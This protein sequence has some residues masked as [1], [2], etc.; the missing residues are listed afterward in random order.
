MCMVM[1]A[2]DAFTQRV[3]DNSLHPCVTSAR[4][5]SVVPTY[6]SA[7]VIGCQV[8][9]SVYVNYKKKPKET[10]SS[11]KG[12]MNIVKKLDI[13]MSELSSHSCRLIQYWAAYLL[14]N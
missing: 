1:L 14:S 12:G 3:G 5:F 4:S 6:T 11:L 9:E 7:N 10:Y 2:V 13:L 8:K